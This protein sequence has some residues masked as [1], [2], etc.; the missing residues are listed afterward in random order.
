MAQSSWEWGLISNRKPIYI[1]QEQDPTI[2]KW[3]D[4]GAKY[5][6]ESTGVFNTLEK[7]RAHLKCGAKWFITPAPS[8]NAPIFVI[9]MNHEKHGSSWKIGS[10]ASCANTYLVPWPRSSM[11]TLAS[12][13][14]HDH[15][16]YNHYHPEVHGW[17][18]WEAVRWWLSS[19]PEHHLCFYWHCQGYGKGHPWCEWKGHWHG[20]PLPSVCW[21]RIWAATQTKLP[22]TMTSRRCKRGI[23]GHAK[24]HSG[25]HRRPGVSCTF[26]NKTHSST[27]DAG[28]GHCSQSPI[29][30]AHFLGLQ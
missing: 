1:F 30:Q 8:G 2:I 15:S 10:K 11:T 3:G 25:L 5:V 21:T 26:N 20:F 13:R 23:E 17:P 9:A 4:S 24:G 29:C 18:F 27:F 14:A 16:P 22:N 7:N 12:W 6:V 28:A 19:Y